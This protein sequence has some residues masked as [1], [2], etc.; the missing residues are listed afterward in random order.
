MQYTGKMAEML[1]RKQVSA[2]CMMCKIH[3]NILLY[4]LTHWNN[5]MKIYFGTRYVE[6]DVFT[7]MQPVQW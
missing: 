6:F 7:N 3:N 4:I 5:Y 2:Y 1:L